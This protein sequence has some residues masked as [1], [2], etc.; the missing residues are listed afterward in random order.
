VLEAVE[1]DRGC[2]ACMLGGED[3]RTLY[4]V[5]N[6]YDGTGASDGIV[7]TQPVDVP[8]AGRP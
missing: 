4:I 2:F 3:G 7:L 1:A 6:H 8:H 5:A